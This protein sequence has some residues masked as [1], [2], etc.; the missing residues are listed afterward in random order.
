M[1]KKTIIIIL[2]IIIIFIYCSRNNNYDKLKAANYITNHTLKRSH[3]CCA[4][5]V[6]KAIW[7]GGKPC[8]ILP[9]FAYSDYLPKL[10]FGKVNKDNYKPLKG[11]I[12]VF[13]KVKGHIYGHIAMWNGEQW[14]SDYKQKGIIV[15]KSYKH[16]DYEVFRYNKED[17]KQRN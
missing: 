5:F 2:S 14:I 17:N 16:C 13:P 1:K 12:V 15:S 9:A 6:M 11:D 4:W 10:G 7:A 8:I 3:N